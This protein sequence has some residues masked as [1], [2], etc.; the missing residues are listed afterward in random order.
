MLREIRLYGELGRRFGRVHHLAVE[1]VAEAVRALSVN[2]R[3]FEQALRDHPIGFHILAGREDRADQT[4]LADPVGE[5]E[6]IKI[7]PATAGS[8]G[9]ILQTILGAVMI[10][11]GFVFQQPWLIQLGV[12]LAL[13]GV[14]Q[15]LSPSTSYDTGSDDET[16]QSYIF[17]GAVN[18]TNQGAAVPIGYGEMIVGSHT[19]SMG[20]TVQ[21]LS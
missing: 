10:V 13:G 12:G 3:G 18:T 17:N 1:S 7:I 8:K 4:K 20:L 21:E 15:M 6:V 14:S 16:K 19:I 9:G 2:F 11:A 5:R